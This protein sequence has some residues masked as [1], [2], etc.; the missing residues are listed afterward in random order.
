MTAETYYKVL[1]A[2]GRSFHGGDM[3]Y[4]LPVQDGEAWT[5]GDWHEVEGAL[6]VCG[7]GIHLTRDPAAWWGE[8]GCRCFVAEY[9][10]DFVT[11]GGDKIAVR[12]ARLLRELTHE[13]LVAHRIFLSGE[14]NITEGRGIVIAGD[15]VACVGDS[16]TIQSVGGSATVRARGNATVLTPPYAW[17]QPTIEV[18]E[19]AVWIDRRGGE[20]VIYGEVAR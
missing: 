20:P 14:H 10:G 13:E 18:D 1:T 12:R 9:E 8:E 16:A 5:P 19:R 17:G 2:E 6:R 11:D 7:N 15:A 4:S 3:Q